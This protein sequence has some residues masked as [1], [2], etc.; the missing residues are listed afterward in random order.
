MYSTKEM[1]DES[2]KE[3]RGGIA[4]G[5]TDLV[6]KNKKLKIMSPQHLLAK[7]HTFYLE[8]ICTDQLLVCLSISSV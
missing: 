7:I 1:S 5:K 4:F 2:L 6:K 8:R 3:E